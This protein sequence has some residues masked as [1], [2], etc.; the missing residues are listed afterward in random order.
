MF[1]LN[2]NGTKIL[3]ESNGEGADEF[4]SFK[5]TVGNVY[6][7]GVSWCCNKPSTNYTVTISPAASW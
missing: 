6:L 1:I 3:A 5:A 4:T 7:L 2:S